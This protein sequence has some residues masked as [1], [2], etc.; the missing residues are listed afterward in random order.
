MAKHKFLIGLSDKDGN[1]VGT[2][3]ANCSLEV[4]YVKGAV[5][6]QILLQECPRRGEDVNQAAFRVVREATND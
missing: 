3:R 5:P 4:V 6:Q 1:V 2:K